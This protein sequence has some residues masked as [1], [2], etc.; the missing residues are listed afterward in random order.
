M[1]GIVETHEKHTKKKLDTNICMYLCII[2]R[3]GVFMFATV[4]IVVYFD[5]AFSFHANSWRFYF[6]FFV[7]W[8]YQIF[9]VFIDRSKF[10]FNQIIV[11][12]IMSPYAITDSFYKLF[13][14]DNKSL[15][16]TDFDWSEWFCFVFLLCKGFNHYFIFTMA[17]LRIAP[18]RHLWANFYIFFIIVWI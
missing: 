2:Y 12:F 18:R 15:P 8:S 10:L 4:N 14:C 5:G 9:D 11:R 3:F 13:K 1:S 17:P 16:L 6:Y 7:H